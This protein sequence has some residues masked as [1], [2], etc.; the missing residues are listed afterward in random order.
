MAIQETVRAISTR[1]KKRVLQVSGCASLCQQTPLVLLAKRPA[2]ENIEKFFQAEYTL[3]GLQLFKFLFGEKL[4]KSIED[5]HAFWF[6]ALASAFSGRMSCSVD[7][8]L[9]QASLLVSVAKNIRH[10]A[11][12]T[13]MSSMD[14]THL[15]NVVQTIHDGQLEELPIYVQEAVNQGLASLIEKLYESGFIEQSSK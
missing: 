10:F 1:T 8:S 2:K 3:H 12:K 5:N 6:D 4:T 15:Q 9:S 11:E 13:H 14:L 7:W